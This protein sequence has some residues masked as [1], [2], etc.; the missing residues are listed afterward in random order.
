M[1]LKIALVNYIGGSGKDTVADLITEEI[2]NV[3]KI[4]LSEGIYEIAKKYYKVDGKPPRALLHHIG[5]SLREYDS[6]LWIKNAIS[7]VREIEENGLADCIIITDVRKEIELE[8]M[9][10]NDFI[11]IMVKCN[12]ATAIGRCNSR[13]NGISDDDVVK[14][15]NSSLENELRNVEV[16]YII[17]N[18]GTLNDLTNNVKSLIKDYL[19]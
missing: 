2:G 10:A 5:E 7:K 15:I 13:D 3:S 17:E 19:T 12:Y 6:K 18:N 11:T 16:D 14:M 4:A 9:V 1:V 8:E